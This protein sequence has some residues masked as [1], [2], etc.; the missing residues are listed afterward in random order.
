MKCQ[1]CDNSATVH[2]KQVLEEGMMELHLCEPCA[3]KKGV[4]DLS[5]FSLDSL[6]NE[7]ATFFDP[8]ELADSSK[9]DL[10]DAKCASCGFTYLDFKK[11]G[12]L[13]CSECY[14]VFE[15]EVSVLLKS[16]HRGEEHKG[17]SPSGMFEVLKLEKELDDAR[18]KLGEAIQSE[19]F[20]KAA[21]IR[22]SIKQLS[23]E[24][25]T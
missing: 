22:D 18:L 21:Q 16:M 4:T 8:D 1:F 23:G 14:T 20:E 19:D 2:F 7:E 15:A 12:R 25:N 10:S 5:S 9:A 6:V 3:E 13:G 24:E 17:K 11:V